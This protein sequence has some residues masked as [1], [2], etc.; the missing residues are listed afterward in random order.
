MV[1]KTGLLCLTGGVLT[2][3]LIL[4]EYKVVSLTSVVTF[5]IAGIFK[6][7]GMIGLSVAVFGD[8]LLPVN[9]AGLLIS[10]LGIAAYNMHK[11]KKKRDAR[12]VVS[13][14]DSVPPGGGLRYSNRRLA[15]SDF[16]LALPDTER[17]LPALVNPFLGDEDYAS[18]YEL[19]EMPGA[20]LS[21]LG[22]PRSRQP[23][24]GSTGQSPLAREAEAYFDRMRKQWSQYPGIEHHP[25]AVANGIEQNR[26]GGAVQM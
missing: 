2:F 9:I 14:L 10:I 25:G 4:T 12:R 13:R 17:P 5:S 8:R 24:A 15:H 6:E 18:E 16:Y 7:L 23:T 26:R 3:A 22:A 21:P 19:E 11:T 20:S 1:L